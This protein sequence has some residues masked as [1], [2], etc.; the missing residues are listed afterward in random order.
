MDGI[1]I[2]IK[3][4]KNTVLRDAYQ[5]HCSTYFLLVACIHVLISS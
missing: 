2:Q 1:C 3:S 5:Y 4:G